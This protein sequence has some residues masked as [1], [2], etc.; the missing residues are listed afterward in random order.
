MEGGIASAILSLGGAHAPLV[1]ARETYLHGSRLS[2]VEELSKNPHYKIPGFGNSFFKD[3]IDPAWLPVYEFIGDN[4]P[5]SFDR[6]TQVTGFVKE[7]TGKLLFPNAALFTAVVCEICEIPKGYEST[8]F[9][10][11]RLPIWVD[12]AQR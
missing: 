1:P 12:Y 11:A 4:F 8:L 7:A 9:I 2:M 3:S 6:I 5:M 10:M